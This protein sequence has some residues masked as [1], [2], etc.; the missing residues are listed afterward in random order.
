MKLQ[1]D[2]TAT[3]FQI[4]RDVLATH[5]GD[6]CHVWVFGSRAKNTARFNSDLDLAIE[7]THPFSKQALIALN[8]AFDEAKL[9]FSV[10]VIDL[11]V[12]EPYF[13][14]IIDSHK[15]VFP[16]SQN[17]PQL[18]FPEF[19]GEWVEKGIGSFC[20]VG[21][22]DHR[23]PK[24]VE[25]GIPYVMTG[26]FFG[27]N[28]ID[29]NNSKRIS[30]QDYDL[31]SRKIKPEFGDVIIARYASV[32]A[33]RY[34][35]TNIEFLV[36]YSCAIIKCFN[37]FYS[38]YL[39]YVLQSQNIQN[40][41]SLIVN[42]SSQKNIGIDSLKKL[43]VFLPNLPEQTKI[44][45]FLSAVD[46]KIDQ[47]TQK[48][49]LLDTYKKGA[50]Q[51][52]F[53]QQIR[54]KADDGEEYPE[55]EEKKLEEVFIYK[56]GGSF[57]KD[58]IEDGKFNLITLNSLDISGNLKI[59]HKTISFCDGSLAKNDLIM[60]L[61][62]VAHGNFLGL[63]A[64]I[65][66]DNKYVLNQRMGALKPKTADSVRYIRIFI[67]F[68]QKYFKLYGQGSSQQNLSKGDI[69]EFIIDLPCLE[70]QIKIATFLSAIDRKIELVSQHLE[71]AKA[72]KK[73]LLQQ[74]FV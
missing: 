54:F 44:A 67:N 48:K 51:Q 8:E 59:N 39:Y 30:Q 5:L 73:G 18:R 9:A 24:S 32:G 52:I 45:T 11:K 14:V 19:S 26:D 10:D 12:V 71:Q 6:E 47:L 40:Y 56:N 25:N 62:D 42:S 35:E 16:L 50:M 43:T 58:V 4:V 2:I 23:M 57:E 53:S 22:I 41:I 15:V 70:E 63:T 7:C 28:E 65:P 29:F 37:G 64:I 69:E 20:K 34:V 27:I 61:S 36:S 38:K 55:W 33:V 17:V 1:F 49:A 60:V 68:N 74:M 31:L 21:D 72:F 3:E 46:T 66:E 13:K